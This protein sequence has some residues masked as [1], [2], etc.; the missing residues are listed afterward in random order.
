MKTVKSKLHWEKFKKKRG[1]RCCRVAQLRSAY[2]SMRR[3]WLQNSRIFNFNKTSFHICISFS[4]DFSML[5]TWKNFFNIFLEPT[6]DIGLKVYI[7]IFSRKICWSTVKP[8]ALLISGRQFSAPQTKL[9]NLAP[10]RISQSNI[11][12]GIRRTLNL[13]IFGLLLAS[14]VQCFKE[15]IF[16]LRIP[17]CKQ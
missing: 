8:S 5:A 16:S 14:W 13:W 6:V 10:Y 7:H 4:C 11:Y 3:C 12:W 2:F 9:L 17:I 1:N 15:V